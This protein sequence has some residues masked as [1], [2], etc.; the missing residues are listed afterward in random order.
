MLK[1][2]RC[3]VILSS[4]ALDRLVL[5]SGAVPRDYLTLSANA[6]NQART[7]EKARVVG[8]QD[9]GRSASQ[10]AEVKIS[11]LEEDGA[12]TEGMSNRNQRS[13]PDSKIL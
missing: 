2:H 13:R 10:I 12:S 7:R 3:Q 11:E 4:K 9:V 6:I 1:F 5:A 8:V